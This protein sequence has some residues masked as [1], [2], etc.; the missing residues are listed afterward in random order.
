MYYNNMV[1][2]VSQRNS[3]KTWR[4]SE[5][6]EVSNKPCK[7]LEK[8][9][10]PVINRNKV[11]TEYRGDIEYIASTFDS[12]V[13]IE[14]QEKQFCTWLKTYGLNEVEVELAF[15]KFYR[16]L[17]WKEV[18]DELSFINEEAARYLWRKIRTKL[19]ILGITK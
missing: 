12:D 5:G 11:R 9:L 19:R 6:C 16:N 7:H 3:K 8:L 2:K 17:T 14:Y 1:K 10:P 18:A 4:C 13:K 15:T